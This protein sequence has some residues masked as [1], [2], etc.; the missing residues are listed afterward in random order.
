[1]PGLVKW[2]L[3]G[4]IAVGGLGV[5]ATGWLV[6]F[7]P[8]LLRVGTGYAAKIIC[9]NVF[10]AGRDA[11]EVLRDDVQAPGHP[12]LR[13]VSADVDLEVGLVRTAMLGVVAPSLALYRPGLGCANVDA[14]DV[15]AARRLT[16]PPAEAVAVDANLPWPEGEGEAATDPRLAAVLADPAL[17]GPG[18]RAVVVVKDGR[19]V[20]EVY[21]PGFNRN[22]PL[23]GWSM[24][25]TVTAALVGM[26]EGE[27]RIDPDARGLFGSWSGDGRRDI[28][29]ADLLA[30]QS[31]I[32]FNESYGDVTDV[33]RMLY[34]ER[35]MAAYAASLPASAP[36]A[37]RFNYSSGES[38]LISRY[39]MSRFEDQTEARAFPRKAL[40]D[41][42][43]M[44]S[45][46]L[47]AD[48]TG[49]FVGSSYLYATARDWARFGLL[50][51]ENG[52]W[53][54]RQIIDP[55]VVAQMMRRTEVSNGRYTHG[56]AWQN[57]PEDDDSVHGLP[58]E[59][60]WMLGHDGQSIAVIASERLVVVRLGLTPRRLDHKPQKLVE[61]VR[62]ALR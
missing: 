1:M 61:A 60:V 45:A 50:V 11:D 62:Q 46:V 9:S 4:A 58:D 57:G 40:F 31:G 33:T 26:L 51:S 36:P 34:L 16:A 23:L 29:L 10:I 5:V 24:T 56:Q 3:R 49:T 41:V 55:S 32:S 59:T 17:L 14:T 35:D 18:S 22:T 28:Q 2:V 30:M 38:V 37:T 8:E 6:A 25:K 52:M 27:G 48:Q 12:L 21:G 47:E 39:W 13:L 42:I 44:H 54:E 43:G 7:P 15:D 20:G 53:A 19:I